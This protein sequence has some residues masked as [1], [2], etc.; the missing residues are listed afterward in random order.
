MDRRLYRFLEVG[1]VDRLTQ[2]GITTEDQRQY[3][4]VQ[5]K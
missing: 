2:A 3:D 4:K 1:R 5:G